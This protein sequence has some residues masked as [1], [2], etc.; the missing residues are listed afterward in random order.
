M[1]TS[2][3]GEIIA[4]LENAKGDDFDR[5]RHAFAF[6]NPR[7]MQMPHGESGKTR[8]QVLEGYRRHNAKIDSLIEA[9]KAS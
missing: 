1:T 4:I 2:Q 8:E 5:A 3:K 7:E 6:M 9:V